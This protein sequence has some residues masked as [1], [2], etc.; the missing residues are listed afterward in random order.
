MSTICRVKIDKDSCIGCGTCN[1]V[2]PQAFSL[3][4]SEMVSVV[5]DGAENLEDDI[6]QEAAESCPTQSIILQ[7]KEGNQI[8][9]K[10]S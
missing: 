9:P 6:L 4:E 5:K 2:A 10:E 3:D 8:Y 1:V 7:D